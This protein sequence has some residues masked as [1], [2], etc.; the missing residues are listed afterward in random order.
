VCNFNDARV[1]VVCKPLERRKL[2]LAK[3]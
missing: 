3:H 1:L 2:I